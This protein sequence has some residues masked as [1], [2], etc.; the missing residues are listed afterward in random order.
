MHNVK[1]FIAHHRA[2]FPATMCHIRAM[3]GRFPAELRVAADTTQAIACL[4]ALAKGL[5]RDFH[6]SAKGFVAL[7]LD[8]F[9]DKNS[10]VCRNTAAAL[11][12]MHRCPPPPPPL[13]GQLLF[14]VMQASP[15]TCQ[16]LLGPLAAD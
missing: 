3:R 7:L 14:Q 13:P 8:K 15:C 12:A 16:Q 9:K 10:G 5:R 6:S 4:Q 2:S 11:E 1:T